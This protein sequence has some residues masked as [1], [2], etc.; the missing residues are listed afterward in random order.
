MFLLFVVICNTAGAGALPAWEFDQGNEL[1]DWV[2]NSHVAD[3]I[4]ENGIL[5]AR[6]ADWDAYFLNRTVTF[7]TSPYQSVLI[8]MR[9]THGGTAELFWSGLLEGEYGGLTPS[10][11]LQF[12]VPDDQE[13]HE[14]A[15]FPFWHTEDKIRQLRLDLYSGATFEIDYIRILAWD[16][17]TPPVEQYVW[18]GSDAWLNKPIFPAAPERFA[19]PVSLDVSDKFWVT[20]V[21][22]ADEETPASLIW[23]NKKKSGINQR[24]F[25][26]RGGGKPHTYNLEMTGLRTWETPLV[27]IGLQIPRPDG[28]TIESLSIQ[29]MPGGGADVV[30]PYFSFV[31]A[32]N[33][34][35]K[36]CAVMLRVA[37][38]G[39]K[40]AAVT[41]VTLQ[42]SA[43]IQ[44]TETFP[45]ALPVSVPFGEFHDFVWRIQVE[46]PGEYS[47]SAHITGEGFD[48]KMTTVLRFDPPAQAGK[49]DYV[50][51][52]KPVPTTID[53]CAYY[54][55]GWDAPSK[56]DCIRNVAPNRKPVLGYYDESLPE[57]VDWQIKWAVEN[58]ITC[59]LVDWYW[60]QGAQHLTHWFEA[61]RQ[62]RYRDVLK[63]AIMWANHN[64]PDTHS[65]DDWRAV[66]QEWIEKYFTLPSYYRVENKPLVMIW[67]P[68]TLRRDLE[69]RSENVRDALA[70]SQRMAQ[71]AGFD[72][73]Y[74]VAMGYDFSSSQMQRLWE[75]GYKAVTTYHEWG[76]AV[77]SAFGVRHLTFESV[78]QNSPRAWN[79]K[80]AAADKLTYLPVVDT[81]WDSRP[82]HGDESL[83]ISG[84][85]PELFEQL[86]RAA[87]AFCEQHPK[88]FLVLGP[89]N[90]WG[91]GSYIE[92]C[93]EFGFDMLERIPTVFAADS[94]DSFP[95]N[96]AP[97]DVGLGPYDFPPQ[98]PKTA[99]TFDADAEGWAAVMNIGEFSV[100]NGALHFKTLSTDP[101]LMVSLNSLPA[102]KYPRLQI[103][104]AVKAA[105]GETHTSA[106]VF[107]S[108]GGSAITEATSVS[109]EVVPD[110]QLR[111]YTVELSKNP[112]WRGKIPQLRFDPVDIPR[113]EITI[114]E[115]RFLT[116]EE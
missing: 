46:S 3:A 82:W 106:Q 44:V 98:E 23:A 31:N 14:F 24:S 74:F 9:A 103:R 69:K 56:W 4:I 19:P 99:W 30:I 55:P 94:S 35:G 7:T 75:E 5:R 92:P 32:P 90:E 116:P 28:V 37:N 57:C 80:H 39:G 62:A 109:F 38:R 50:P 105:Q 33:R 21:A 97:E 111:E 15:L 43:D 68:N 96:L 72:G 81:G 113:A 110:G 59:F 107:W 101:A 83:V 63:V 48:E 65:L 86:L 40:D 100:Q 34:A 79:E 45:D 91:E 8:R 67:D 6:G 71:E 52:P 108:L 76:K 114:E 84:R 85:T 18:S 47:L 61:Y 29:D 1:T 73:I 88:P 2:P 58:G 93:T 53:V 17:N 49:S 51:E 42:P 77:D 95:V 13:W 36:P 64:P 10:K 20:L 78:V 12:A 112:R 16:N 60:I 66:T 102:A 104:M 26:L 22:R 87:K 89:M 70:M 115:I 27:A 11:R 41:N 54:F 25:V